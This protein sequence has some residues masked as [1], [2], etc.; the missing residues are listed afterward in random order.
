MFSRSGSPLSGVFEI[1]PNLQWELLALKLVGRLSRESLEN[2]SSD[3]RSAH[4]SSSILGEIFAGRVI[5]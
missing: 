5:G 4:A 2:L 1:D 3:F